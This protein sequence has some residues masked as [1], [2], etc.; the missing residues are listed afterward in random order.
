MRDVPELDIV[1]GKVHRGMWAEYCDRGYQYDKEFSESDKPKWYIIGNSFG[2]DMVNIILESEMADKVE[3]SYSAPPTYKERNERFAKA[4][5]IFVTN[6]PLS[7]T[8]IEDVKSRCLLH[9]RFIVL[10][11]KNFGECNGQI[12]RQ[13]FS[14]DFH[15]LTIQIDNDYI[16]KNE[17]LK[18]IYPDCFI[19]MIEM[20]RQPDGK[21]KVFT[22]DN[23]FISQ[24]CIHL[25]KAG[26]QFYAGMMDWKSFM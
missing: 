11:E 5:V 16:E 22:E 19:D 8:L 18:A 1:K 6:L 13:R 3:I 17:R 20:V 7:E 2:R 9:T 15:Q 21:V 12:Y 10:G 25:T 26:A 4:D 23:R 24:D 14:Y